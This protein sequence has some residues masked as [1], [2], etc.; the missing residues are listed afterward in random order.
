[1]ELNYEGLVSKIEEILNTWSNRNISLIGK[2]NIVNTLCGSLFVYKMQVLPNIKPNLI[3]RIEKIFLEYLWNKGK[4]KI[5]LR[6]LQGNKVDGGLGLI[7]LCKKEMSLKIAWIPYLQKDT[8]LANL[9]Y[10]ALNTTLKERIWECNLKKEDIDKI[11]KTVIKGD[12]GSFW[13]QVLYAWCALNYKESVSHGA[14][15][16]M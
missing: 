8:E 9:A 6:T 12:K 5:S 11:A 7:D 4:P 3:N 14:L 2:I 13:T 15:Q 10:A 1:M 16:C